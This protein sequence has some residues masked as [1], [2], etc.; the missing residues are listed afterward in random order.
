[1]T[2]YPYLRPREEPISIEPLVTSSAAFVRLKESSTPA[3]I[4]SLR[5]VKGTQSAM[6][7]AAAPVSAV[8]Q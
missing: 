7:V 6:T 3:E 1:M 8:D 5:Y 2:K 4:M